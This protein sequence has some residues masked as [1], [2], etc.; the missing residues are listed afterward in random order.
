M[1]RVHRF[2]EPK[3]AAYMLLVGRHARERSLFEGP[4]GQSRRS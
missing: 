2:T 3:T 1:T 4:V